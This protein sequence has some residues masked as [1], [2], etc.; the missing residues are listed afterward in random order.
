M[1]VGASPTLMALLALPSRSVAA[2]SARLS[3]MLRE[4]LAAGVTTS[5]YWVGLT[6]VSAPFA[7]PSLTLM[8]LVSKPVTGSLKVKV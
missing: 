5:V 7:A 1:A 6:A 4:P 3:V 2:P 8:S